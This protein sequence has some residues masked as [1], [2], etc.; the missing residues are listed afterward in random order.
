MSCTILL[1]IYISLSL[2]LTNHLIFRRA[3]WLL[4]KRLCTP[5]HMYK[6][7]YNVSPL[8][9]C[10]GPANAVQSACSTIRLVK[11]GQSILKSLTT[12]S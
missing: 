1:Y 2:S 12:Q 3:S 5:Q 6:N 8:K 4:L 7:L 9:A 11:D 10:I